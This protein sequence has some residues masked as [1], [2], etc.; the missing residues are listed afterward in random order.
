MKDRKC[1]NIVGPQV[2]RLRSGK[3]WSQERLASEL[4][5]HGWKISRCGVARIESQEVWVGDFETML[6]ADA[7]GVDMR[8]LFPHFN[9]QQP[10]YSSVNKMLDGQVKSVMSPEEILS[11]ESKRLTA[12]MKY[13]D[14][15]KPI[16]PAKDVG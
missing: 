11:A 12:S 9:E 1:R 6:M 13:P 16:V 2:R 8:E 14:G 7:L 3:D 4:Q 15:E 5:M 10:L